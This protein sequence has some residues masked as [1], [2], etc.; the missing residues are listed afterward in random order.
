MRATFTKDERLCSRKTLDELFQKGDSYSNYPVRV[1]WMKAPAE[2]RFPAQVA[3]SV[4]KRKVRKAA[5]RNRIKRQLKEAYRRNKHLLYE[6]LK[7]DGHQVVFMLIY[8]ARDPLE[9]KELESKI[10]V[11][12]QRLYRRICEP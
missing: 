9:Y 6:P 1:I 4:P 5:H 10:I 11:S 8:L 3:I 2:M 7:Q 12:L